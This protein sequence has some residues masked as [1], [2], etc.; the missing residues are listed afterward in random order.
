MFM[1]RGESAGLKAGQLVVGGNM[2]RS[3]VSA[4]CTAVLFGVGCSKAEGPREVAAL[5]QEARPLVK[6][7]PGVSRTAFEDGLEKLRRAHQISPRDEEVTG[8]LVDALLRLSDFQRTRSTTAAL[9]L[10]EEAVGLSNV[11]AAASRVR[12]LGLT[13]NRELSD[14]VRIDSP[15]PVVS[16]RTSSLSGEIAE[17]AAIAEIWVGGSRLEVEGGRFSRPLSALGEGDREIQLSIRGIANHEVVRTHKYRVDVTA[18]KLT[19]TSPEPDAWI[20]PGTRVAGAVTDQSEVTVAHGDASVEVMPLVVGGS[21]RPVRYE[22]PAA[23][24]R[25]TTSLAL[26][27]TDRAGHT[28]RAEVAVRVDLDHPEIEGVTPLSGATR[29]LSLTVSAT[30]RD[31]AS[32][33]GSCTVDGQEVQIGADGRIAHRVDVGDRAAVPIV[34][35]AED[36]VGNRISH[37][38]SITVDRAGPEIAALSGLPSETAPTPVSLRGH[39]R[40]ANGSHVRVDGREV[41]VERGVFQT[42]IE[43]SEPG[44]RTIEVLAVDDLG[45]ESHELIGVMVYPGCKPCKI[46]GSCAYCV[47]GGASSCDAC[48]GSGDVRETCPRCEGESAVWCDGGCSGTGQL[49]KACGSC[50]STGRVTCSHCNGQAGNP[51]T[52]KTCKGGGYLRLIDGSPGHSWEKNVV[53]CNYCLGAGQRPAKCPVCKQKRTVECSSCR[54]RLS[55]PCGTCGGSGELPCTSC[56]DG[57]MVRRCHKCK[58][59]PRGVEC[60]RCGGSGHCTDCGGAGFLRPRDG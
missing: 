25:S 55:S 11:D 31:L 38:I 27:A 7:D 9:V 41:S 23:I 51:I 6:R 26:V 56:E 50:D 40:D 54:G 52:C 33:I 46:T 37:E 39:V 35:A 59:D 5:I 36:R 29:E 47:G 19:I 58:G 49:G 43:L 32:G 53:K 30:I 28:D 8:L 1:S 42:T 16:G 21:R 22:I 18:P 15:G 24:D 60:K 48:G 10:A 2:G 34:I 12:D 57:T 44:P 3:L 4:I 13:L 20:G 17:G 14:A 45:N